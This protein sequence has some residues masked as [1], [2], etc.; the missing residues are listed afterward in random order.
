MNGRKKKKKESAAL[1][2]ELGG[3]VHA[4]PLLY[5]SLLRRSKIKGIK[6]RAVTRRSPRLRHRT[7][8]NPIFLLFVH[9]ERR[10]VSERPSCTGSPSSLSSLS[11]VI[12]SRSFTCT[13]TSLCTETR[14]SA[15]LRL[16]FVHPERRWVSGRPSCGSFSSLSSLS[17]VIYSRSLTRIDASLGLFKTVS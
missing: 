11:R 9:P 8:I 12:Y 4:F 15:F 13:D 17:I 2:I 7:N 1:T 10:E 14:L 16:L 3:Q 6:G 5:F